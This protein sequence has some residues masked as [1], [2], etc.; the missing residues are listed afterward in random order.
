MPDKE[1]VVPNIEELAVLPDDMV[2]VRTPQ[3]NHM[4]CFDNRKITIGNEPIELKNEGWEYVCKAFL[5][6]AYNPRVPASPTM[7]LYKIVA[8]SR[9]MAKLKEQADAQTKANKEKT[10]A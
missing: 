4:L 10:K 8:F 2:I 6:K 5:G 9:T 7:V 1:I 3:G